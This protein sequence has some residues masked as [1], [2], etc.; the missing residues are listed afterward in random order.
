MSIVKRVTGST[1]RPLG[2]SLNRGLFVAAF[3]EI[4]WFVASKTDL[5]VAEDLGHLIAASTLVGFILW[6]LWDRYG[7]PRLPSA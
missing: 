3:Q 1:D 2:D 7:R 6:G 4:V 5:L